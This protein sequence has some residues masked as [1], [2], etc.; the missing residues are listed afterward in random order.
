M[1][2]FFVFKHINVLHQNISGLLNKSELLGVSLDELYNLNKQV[3]I[4]CITEHNMISGDEN[5]LNVENF[6]L[7]AS[8][9]RNERRG[10]ACI[11]VRN[12]LQYKVLINV[13]DFSIMNIVECCGIELIEHNVVIIALYRVPKACYLNMFF[14]LLE[15]MLIEVTKNLI[16]KVILCGDFNID[17]LKANNVTL[18]FENILLCYNMKLSVRE[19]TRPSS[20]TCIDNIINN[21]RGGSS[22]VIDM[23]LSDHNAQL[24][25]CPVKTTCSLKSWTVLKRDL[26]LENLNIFKQCLYSL[27]FSEVYS[28]SEPNKAYSN[29]L[30]L[31]KLFY[32]LCFPWKKVCIR[33]KKRQRWISKGIRQ[34]SRRKRKLL[35]QYRLSPTLQNKRTF[36]KYSTVY[37]KIIKLTK[38][39]QNNHHI[40]SSD[41]KSRATWQVINKNKNQY[42]DYIFSITHKQKTMT[43][44]VEIAN[45]FNNAFI[46]HIP[47][48]QNNTKKYKDSPHCR[49]LEDNCSSMFLN[50]TS[51]QD[52]NRK[53]FL[54]K[55]TNSVGYDNIA[56]KVVKHVREIV[57]FPLCY[58][59]NMCIEKGVFPEGLKTSIIKPLFKQG[60]KD[61]VTNYRP[62]ALIPIFSKVLEKIIYDGLYTYLEQ[63][64]I[65]INEQKGFRK[66]KS[67]NLAIYD[68]LNCVIENVDNRNPVCAIY[69]DMSKAFDCVDHKILAYKL[70]RYGIRG[71]VLDLIESYLS[72]R[73]QMTEINRIN[74]NSKMEE[75]YIS[76]S[77]NI[78]FGVPQGSV[79]GPLLFLC[80]INDLPKCTKYPM[81]LFADDSTVIIN[82]HDDDYLAQI[83]DTLKD[84]INWLES[85]NL[86]IN[87]NKTKVM[88]FN[89]RP[90]NN[91]NYDIKYLNDNI[92]ETIVTKFLGLYIDRQLTW[93]HHI[94][95]LIKRI[96]SLAYALKHLSK[97][98]NNETALTAY[99]GSVSSLLRYGVIFWA[100]STNKQDVFVA[101]KRCVRAIS[102]L[103]LT[104]SCKPHFKTLKILTVPC[105]YIYEVALFVKSNPMYFPTFRERF[106]FNMR[107]GE[108]LCNR[109]S[110]TTLMYNSLFCMAPKIFN[111]LPQTLKMQDYINFKTKL[112]YLLVDKCY[113][114]ITEFLNDP[115]LN[116]DI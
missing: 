38:L 5:V 33:S 60:D 12:H 108:M 106:R 110:R 19:P 83:T 105:L 59:F 48:D 21:V 113:Y 93:K 94:D 13:Q 63:N 92:N 49:L 8:Y 58:I 46:N 84:I 50:P 16:K 57:C 20:N 27:S 3:D 14:E 89:Q 40:K 80:Y 77:Q 17:I 102:N 73:N 55:N 71:N 76:T 68:F 99:H 4:L 39:A 30:E 64:K 98:V 101:Q 10:G 104:D 9:F 95:N 82:K 18:N 42:K 74:I 11:L 45:T 114:S 87:L 111:K 79:L 44:P 47:A 52:I 75:T 67:I 72:N 91:M 26:S 43:D 35:W 15:K 25:K 23:A 2:S 53:I 24:F 115:N 56:T 1:I 51:P 28:T 69:M 7:A 70:E 78:L 61:V 116:N 32:D 90:P 88:R 29:F 34:C 109:K 81:V 22:E 97:V 6:K 107:N 41:N 65:L 66:G 85:N 86:K 31:F 112:K 36:K 62:V 100:N 54:L 103:K 96:N 37:K